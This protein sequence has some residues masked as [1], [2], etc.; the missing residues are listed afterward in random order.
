M[1]LLNSCTVP[2][3]LLFDITFILSS[4]EGTDWGWDDG[5]RTQCYSRC[6]A[7]TSSKTELRD[8]IDCG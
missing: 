8:L 6:N 4:G 3:F 1:T 2:M 5:E 7:V